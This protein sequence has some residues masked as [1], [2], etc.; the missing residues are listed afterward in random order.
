G[1]AFQTPQYNSPW[2]GQHNRNAHLN[3]AIAY[4]TIAGTSGCRMCHDASKLEPSTQNH[5]SGLA[6]PEFE[7]LPDTTLRPE[8][9]Y[10]ASRSC[11]I[12][13]LATPGA[14]LGCHEDTS[15][16]FWLGGD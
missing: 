2:S 15:R 13:S 7:T 10:D 16:V 5:F 4:A 11:S 9:N 3:T 12:T 14:P 8:L 6:T 1:T